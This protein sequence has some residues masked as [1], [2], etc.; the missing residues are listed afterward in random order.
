MSDRPVR[1]FSDL[2]A[3]GM[4]WAVNATLL[5]PRG[6]ALAVEYGDAPGI[7]TGPR[8][9]LGWKLLGDGSEPWTF[10]DSEEIHAKFRA[11]EAFLTEHRG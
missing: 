9:A 2:R 7:V 8:D 1:P 3:T 6:F 11:F 5:H 10:T 4:L